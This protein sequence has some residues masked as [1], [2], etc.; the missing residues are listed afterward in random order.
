MDGEGV[1]A[2]GKG[3]CLDLDTGEQTPGRASAW[4]SNVFKIIASECLRPGS[5][6]SLELS[7]QR[8]ML[9]PSPSP[10]S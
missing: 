4:V 2:G 10:C 9:E 5:W 3:T 6:E 1:R 8:E 7:L